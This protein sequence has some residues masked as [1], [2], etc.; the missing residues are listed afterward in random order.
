VEDKPK[1]KFIN[2]KSKKFKKPNHFH[3]SPH[4]NSSSFK[5]FQS[6]SFK[7]KTSGHKTDERFY[8]VH[9]RTNHLAPQCFNRRTESVKAQ[10]RENE[11]NDGHKVNM[12]ELN[13]N[14]FRLDSSLSIVNSI[15]FSSNWWLDSEVNIHICTDRSWFK[16]YHKQRGG[17]MSLTD[18][19]TR[20]IMKL[21]ALI[22][23]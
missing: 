5:P 13:S 15:T 6:S 12:V 23:K 19:S 7:P 22:S 16:S 2:P 14:S 20:E 21:D 9:R 8:Y 11:G 17:S 3:S 10:L 18:D 4:V 1:R